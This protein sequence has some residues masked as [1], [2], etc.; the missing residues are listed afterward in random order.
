[1]TNFR[2]IEGGKSAPLDEAPLL[3]KWKQTGAIYGGLAA[4]RKGVMPPRLAN[5][6]GLGFLAAV[7]VFGL[8]YV[9]HNYASLVV[10]AIVHLALSVGA[11]I[12]AGLYVMKTSSAP[13]SHVDNLDTLLAAYDPVSK[14]AYRW[15][16]QRVAE[17][18]ALDGDLVEA[19]LERERDAIQLAAGWRMPTEARFLKKRI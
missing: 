13:R 14:D 19:W 10:S 1:M 16:Q 12:G 17:R 15:L 11:G 4:W 6:A 5:A 2:L 3:A 18:G 9:A 7:A 8:I